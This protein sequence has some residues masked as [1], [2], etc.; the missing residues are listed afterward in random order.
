MLSISFYSGNG[1]A[2]DIVRVS[3]D[4]YEW[5]AR[6]STSDHGSSEF[7]KLGRS[8]QTEIEIE[9]ETAELSLV[10]LGAETRSKLIEFFSERIFSETRFPFREAMPTMLGD[11]DRATPQPELSTKTYRLKKL[12][13][14]LDCL[15]SETYQYLQRE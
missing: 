8:Q 6:C 10:P 2:I 5:L 14:V 12:L 15:K 4:F 1:Q 7:S 3:D 11:L 9:G 13:E